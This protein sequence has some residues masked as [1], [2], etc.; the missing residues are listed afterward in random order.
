[1]IVLE[2]PDPTMETQIVDM[3]DPGWAIL[4][5]RNANA[6][7]VMKDRLN[8]VVITSGLPVDAALAFRAIV[9]GH[10]GCAFGHKPY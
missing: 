2:Y 3:L 10:G 6:P 7:T 9:V 5:G 1:M 4:H 8:L